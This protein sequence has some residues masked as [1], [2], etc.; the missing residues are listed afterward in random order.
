MSDDDTAAVLRLNEESVWALSP[1]DAA[2]LAT[3]RDRASH[4]FVG[5]I[6]GTLAAFAIVYSPGAEYGSVNYRW[7][8]ERFDDFLY[9]DRIVVDRS[10]RR[11]GLASAMYD[12]AEEQATAH[13][14]LVCEVYSTPPNEASL[15]FHRNRGFREIGTLRQ[16]G[17]EHECAMFEKRLGTLQ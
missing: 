9:L 16:G 10:F 14:R 2:G 7:F 15:A 6:D 12:H 5:A 1:L 4:P 11:R 8:T 13:G 3:A 17:D